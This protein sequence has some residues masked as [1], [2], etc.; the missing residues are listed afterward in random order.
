M[1]KKDGTINELQGDL[2]SCEEELTT[3]RGIL[4]K[5][6]Q[7]RELIWQQVEEYSEKNMLLNREVVSLKKK[8]EG[9][10]EDTLLKDG[11][12]SILKDSLSN[13]KSFNI[14]FESEQ[15]NEF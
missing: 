3:T 8:I 11:Q 1:I 15:M 2:R 4:A 5:V 10:E 7:E 13:A 12:I 9:L 14:L 6:S